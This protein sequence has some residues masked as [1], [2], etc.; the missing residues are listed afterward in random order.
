MN[1]LPSRPE[2]EQAYLQSDTSYDGVFFLGVNT[3]GIFCRPSCQARKPHPENV[4][5]FASAHD[6]VFAGFRPCKRCRPLEPHGQPPQWI[7]GVLERIDRNPADRITD[8]TLSEM[9]IDPA[10]VRRY[11]QKHFGMTFQAYCRGRRLGK[12]LEQIRRGGNLDDV[13]LG[14]GYESHSGFREAFSRTFGKAPGQ[15]RDADCVL[16]AWMESPVGPLIAA[17]NSEGVCL[18]EFT[19]RR[20]LD[21][22]FQKVRRFFRCPIVPGDNEHLQLLRNELKAYFA[23]ELKRFTVKLVSPGSSF[24]E[25]VWGEL[26][27][28]PYGSTA[29]YEDIAC[30]I[31]IPTAVRAVGH[32]NGL[33]RI[34]IVIPCHRVVNKSGKLGGY[35]GGLWRKKLLLDLERGER[36]FELASGTEERGQ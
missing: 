14:Y 29:S 18:L 2:M 17:A 34:A 13:A 30:R 28:I 10:R 21:A 22:Q 19:D 15:S 25:R 35:G 9:G 20:M 11:F 6:A 32:A 33:N 27:K 1:R 5:F 23:G 8:V 12:S 36:Q 3:T 16:V 26:K 31:G 7:R 24:Q 4:E